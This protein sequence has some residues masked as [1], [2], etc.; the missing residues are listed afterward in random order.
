MQEKK[1]SFSST[2]GFVLTTAG[3][4]VGLGNIW[5]FP[6]LAAKNGG[7]LFLVVYLLLVATFGFALLVTEV[8]IGRKTKS[9][10]I[11]AYEKV[12][13]KFKSLGWFSLII[14]FLILSY[15]GVIGGWVLK[16]FTMYVTGN[17]AD[18]ASTNYFSEYITQPVQPIVFMVIYTLLAA[19]VVFR[20]VNKGVERLSKIIMPI[21]LLIVIGISIYTLTLSQTDSLGNTTTGIDGLLV[22]II[23]DISN[24]TFSKFMHVL[25]DAM[26]QLFFS[27][28][29]A[30]GVIIAF[31][32][33]LGDK[34]N[35]IKCVGQIE[36][37]DTFVAVMAGI[38]VI[39]PIYVTQGREGMN[40]SGP[41]LLFE[42]LPSVFSSLGTGGLI[43]G[44]AFFIMVFFAALTSSIAIM[45]AIIASLIDKFNIS[46][47]KAVII[48]AAIMLAMGTTVCMGYNLLYF[49]VPLPNGS[50]GQLLDVIDYVSN[51]LAMPILAF[52]TCILIGWFTKPSYVIEEATKNGEK[53][54]RRHIYSIVIKY[55][56]PILLV[57]LFLQSLGIF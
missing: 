15:Y 5:R 53:F 57:V 8:A 22:Y 54:R 24:L 27:I 32:S 35:M 39:V 12:H 19:I 17:G 47:K 18:A 41:S 46:R 34:G 25:L 50:H 21:L 33:Y 52:L 28:S 42:S 49:D 23:P 30:C 36:I 4:A 48:E 38:M 56:A 6:Y 40:A 26:G 37:C 2:L 3:S 20:G 10:P 16:Y 44:G 29:V 9:S 1:S 13:P 14:P 31:G 11:M 43:L 55:V 51:S 7:G 45:E